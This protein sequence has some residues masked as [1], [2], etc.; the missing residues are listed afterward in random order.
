MSKWTK[1]HCIYLYT[2]KTN[3]RRRH[4]VGQNKHSNKA[5]KHPVYG[6]PYGKF[7]VTVLHSCLT[8]KQANKLERLEIHNYNCK[9]PNGYNKARGG[10]PEDGWTLSENQKRYGKANPNYGN[11]K[12]IG[13]GRIFSAK[14]KEKMHK[15]ALARD[16]SC[17]YTEN[18]KRAAVKRNSDPIK[19]L[20][21]EATGHNMTIAE[22]QRIN[23]IETRICDCGCN[24]A[25]ECTQRNLR[26]YIHGHYNAKIPREKRFCSCN[27][28]QTFECKTNSKR[29][30]INGHNSRGMFKEKHPGWIPR[31]TRICGCGCNQNFKCRSK[32]KQQFILYHSLRGKNNPGYKHGRCCKTY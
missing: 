16:P 30:F 29:R 10:K 24:Q 12:S 8:H 19:I 4:Y 18:R 7:I 2:H 13:K 23:Q 27:C 9:Y 5:R 15:A 6:I 31:E 1:N 32:S 20:K 11:H 17:Y 14:T 25:F 22:W 26:K 28:G 3:K 21:T